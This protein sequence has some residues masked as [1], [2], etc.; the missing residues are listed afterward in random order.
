MLEGTHSYHV[1]SG[2]EGLQADITWSWWWVEN[3]SILEV[4]M[5][6]IFEALDYMQQPLRW[7]QYNKDN[8][9][10]GM[11]FVFKKVFFWLGF[12]SI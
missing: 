12:W 2:L 9:F 3:E 5:I 11:I 8:G 4:E 1:N 6:K 10:S 7:D